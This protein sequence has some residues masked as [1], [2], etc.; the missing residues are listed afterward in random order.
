LGG[1]VTPTTIKQC[2]NTVRCGRNE[3]CVPHPA[4][5]GQYICSKADDEC[6]TWRNKRCPAGAF[7][8]A[9]PRYTWQVSISSDNVD[10]A[11]YETVREAF[12]KVEMEFV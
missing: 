5:D 7:C 4:R 1:V 6:G 2:P 12:V 9:D 8:L 3:V 10:M 11:N